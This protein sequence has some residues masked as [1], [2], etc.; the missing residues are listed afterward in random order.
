MEKIVFEKSWRELFAESGLQSFDDFCNY[1]AGRVINKNTKRDVTR[2]ELG[3]GKE[4]QVFF[5]KRF[6]NPHF[7]DI[8]GAWWDFGRPT[9]QAALEWS[10]AKLLLSEAIETYHPVCYGQRTICGIERKSFLVTEEIDGCSLSEFV[11]ENWAQLSQ[12]QKEEIVS[13]VGRFVRKIHNA[14]ICMTDLYIWHIFIKQGD[15]AG[16]WD[17]SVID[18]HR[19]KR[20]V[21]NPDALLRNLG[22]FDHSM[23]DEYFDSGLRRL[24]IESYAGSDFPGDIDGLMRKVDKFSKAV[25]RKR[26]VKPY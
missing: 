14:Q 3:A 5:M 16:Q 15:Q 10:N 2:F 9:S 11:A 7:K 19:M 21:R 4:R 1:S 8:A 17:L 13:A 18:L 25:S 6:N 26:N 24:F 22:R 23:R 12:L 20:N